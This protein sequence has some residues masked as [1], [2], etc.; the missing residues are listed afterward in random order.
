MDVNDGRGR[1]GVD[2]EREWPFPVHT[3]V[4]KHHRL[5]VG[6]TDGDWYD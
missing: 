2:D 3:Y 1:P 5:R 6:A 4:G